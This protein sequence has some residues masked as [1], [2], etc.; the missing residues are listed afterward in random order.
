MAAHAVTLGKSAMSLPRE[1]SSVASRST[2]GSFK[3]DDSAVSINWNDLNY[4]PGIRLVHFDPDELPTDVARLARV[5][6]WMF[7]LAFVELLINVTH[8]VVLVIGG[9]PATRVGYAILD[10]VI[11][12]P[13]FG[14][15]FYQGYV[16]LVSSDDKTKRRYFFCQAICLIISLFF[17]VSPLGATNGLAALSSLH[18]RVRRYQLSKGMKAFWIYAVSLESTFWITVF[19]LGV[20]GLAGVKRFNPFHSEAA[21]NSA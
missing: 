12:A 9:M 15:T 6:H 1:N 10:A 5:L 8:T 14:T 11:L 16:A 4:P 3:A 7:L 13:S 21:R 19:C 18:Q 17:A 20:W 2:R